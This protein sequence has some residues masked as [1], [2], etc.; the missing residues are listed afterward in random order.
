MIRCRK[1]GRAIRGQ[2]AI[3]CPTCKTSE[4]MYDDGKKSRYR[5]KYR[6]GGLIASMDELMGQDFVYQGDNIVPAGWFRSWQMNY[7][8]SQIKGRYIR[9]ALKIEE[10]KREGIE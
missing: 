9:R 3:W 8:W 1:C 7:A 5:R 4:Y 10:G 6:K 2:F